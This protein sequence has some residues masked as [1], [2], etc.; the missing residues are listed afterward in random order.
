MMDIQ[1]ISASAGSG[2]TFRLAELLEQ[3]VR[4]GEVRPDAILATT[5][6]KKAAAELQERVRTRLL[7]A[8]LAPQAQQLSASR[9]GTVNSVCGRLLDDFAFD[10]GI[11]P[12]QKVIEEDAVSGMISRAMSRVV[13]KGKNKEIWRLEQLFPG[14]NIREVIE[15]IIAKARANGLGSSDLLQCGIRSF[16]DYRN[17]FG[18]AAGDGTEL[19]LALRNGIDTFLKQVDTK[20]DPTNLTR[21]AINTVRGLKFRSQNQKE[22]PWS[23]WL[24]LARLKTGAK[25]KQ[26]AENLQNAAACH[27]RHPGLAKEASQ[28]IMLVFEMAGK[29]IDAYQEHKREWGVVDFTDQEVLT[30][31]LLDMEQPVRILREHLDLV[32]VDEFQDTS[33]IQLAIFLKLASLAKQS[34]WV[35]DQKQAIYGFRDADPNLMDAAITGILKEKEPETLQYSWRSR[36]ELVRSTS[37][38]FVKAFANQG[39]PEQRVRLEPVAAI[40]KEIAEGLSPPYECW[41]VDSK[42]KENDS[43]ALARL[44]RE[45]LAEPENT[46]RDPK[47]GQKRQ[48]RGGDIAILCRENDVCLDVA[49]ALEQQGIEAALPRPGLRSCPEVILT[50]AGVRLLIDSRDSLARAEIARFLDDPA[51]HNSWLHKALIKPFAQGFDHEIFNRLEQ[52]K[53]KSL[54]V[55]SPLQVLDAAMEATDVRQHCLAWGNSENR[56]ANLDSLRSLCARYVDECRSSSRGASPAGMLA[57]LVALKMDTR[58]VVK[59]ADTIQVLTWHKAKGLEWPVTVLFQLDKVFPALPLGVNVV[60]D[61]DFSLADPLNN[62]WLRFWPNPYGN[63]TTGAPFHGRLAAHPATSIHAER[64][65][66][67]ELRLLYVG[68]TRARDKV[69]LAGRDGFLQKGLL[70]LL[71]D[72][73]GDHLLQPPENGQCNWAGRTTEIRTRTGGPAEPVQ[74]RSQPG[75]GYKPCQLKEY[76]PA[77]QAASSMVGQGKVS[78]ME[79]IGDRLHLTGKPDMQSIGEAI[80]TFLGADDVKRDREKR[81]VMAENVLKHWQVA[82][83]LEPESLLAAS[84]RLCLWVNK[85]W[86]DAIWLKEYPVSLRQGNSMIVS[87]YIDVLLQIENVFVIIDHK[88]FPGSKEEAMKKA[89]NFAGQVGF[90]A[91]AVQAATGNSVVGCFIHLPVTGNI[92]EIE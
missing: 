28:L 17:L 46:V 24:R 53:K 15:T 71:L 33:P 84:D 60:S 47:T 80:H 85:K 67:Q 19:D 25:S 36:P 52:A 49:A 11:S 58:A 42:N 35:G 29:T 55:A 86:P 62:R 3:K 44:V 13:E 79:T 22:I 74:K 76:P 89:A 63:F 9:I 92:V 54:Y 1:I 50:M 87:G 83:N 59:N 75:T 20:S 27:D 7:A 4:G 70:R 18:E 90:Y 32:L 14:T 82:V 78:A 57:Y 40:E 6:T 69:V 5:F 72:E 30:L 81:L 41:D 16:A 39:V 73:Q 26:V 10:L 37:D 45:F 65:R 61:K 51:D 88:S 34:I 8:G 66:R 77:F 56:L 48:V 68:W 43:L 31:K 12:D 21:D 2:K 64:E 91:D 38:I 23:E